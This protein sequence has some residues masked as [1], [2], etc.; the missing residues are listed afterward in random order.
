ATQVVEQEGGADP[1]RMI[2]WMRGDLMMDNGD[3]TSALAEIQVSLAAIDAEAYNPAGKSWMR[4]R[5]AMAHACA[6]DFRSAVEWASAGL[7]MAE[8]HHLRKEELDNLYPL[9]VAYEALGNTRESLRYYKR[10]HAL[11]D[12]VINT[13]SARS[14]SDA[15]L[16]QDFE[17]QQLADSLVA[18]QRQRDAEVTIAKERNRRNLLL[19]AGLV[20]LVFG[21]ISYRQRRK[22][23]K[24]LERSDE[25][26]L[27]ILP[28]EVAEELKTKG[29]ADAKHFDNVTILFTDFKGFTAMS[30]QVSPRQ[31]VHDLNECFSAF[32][33]ITAKHGIESEATYELVKNETGL[34]FTSRG[35]V[36]AKGKGEMEMYFVSRV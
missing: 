16:T 18:M 6:K 30:E 5:I 21:S 8:E 31:L 9:A 35:K 12:S 33:H 10:Y 20:A 17:K 32:D 23:Q 22:T 36:Q 3:C 29:H 19:I 4:S 25:L 15:A 27:N 11:L 7:A 28:E 13:E 14:L 26:L 34:T 2:N 1:E 24:A